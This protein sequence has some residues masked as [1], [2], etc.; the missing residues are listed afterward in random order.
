MAITAQEIAKRNGD[1]GAFTRQCDAEGYGEMH[2]LTKREY[3]AAMA[4]QGFSSN[5]CWAK[6][7][8]P[9]DWEEYT[10]RL[11]KASVELADALLL[12]LSK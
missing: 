12:E 3:F 1:E 2:G 4:M 9:D 11:A 8:S 6:S 7:M 5:E 10:T